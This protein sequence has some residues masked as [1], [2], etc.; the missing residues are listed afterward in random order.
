MLHMKDVRRVMRPKRM[1]HIGEQ[2][3][4]FVACVLNNVTIETGECLL[5]EGMPRALI[6]GLSRLLQENVVA[7][8]VHG[9]QAQAA[10]KRF[11]LGH[12]EV[13]GGHI[14]GQTRAFLSAVRHDGLLHLTVHL[15]LRPIGS[16]NKTIKACELHQQTHEAN[17][18]GTHFRTHQVYPEHQT[19]QESET[20]NTLK[21]GHDRGTLVE[22]CLVRLPRLEGAAGNIKLLGCLTL[23]EALGLELEIL[24]KAFSAFQAT[25]SREVCLIAWLPGLD[26][27]SHSA[28][29]VHPLP[30]YGHG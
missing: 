16:G 19:M 20:W 5:H 12:R 27:G 14:F 2:G 13:F 4:C 25:P 22:T 28:L 3:R 17:A 1:F 8:G 10:G 9:H 21:K 7:L 24:I 15:V 30:W 18:T 26:Y 11:I 23:G 29:L 6:A